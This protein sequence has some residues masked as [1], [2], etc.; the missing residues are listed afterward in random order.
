MNKIHHK[1]K[2]RLLVIYIFLGLIIVRMDHVKMTSVYALVGRICHNPSMLSHTIYFKMHFNII[3]TSTPSLFLRGCKTTFL[4]EFPV[5]PTRAVTLRPPL[6]FCTAEAFH[7]LMGLSDV[8]ILSVQA[9]RNFMKHIRSLTKTFCTVLTVLS[10][11]KFTV[12]SPR[13]ILRSERVYVYPN[14]LLRKRN[15]TDINNR[16]QLFFH[17]TIQRHKI[18]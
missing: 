6:R 2:V 13:H 3:V 14:I 9:L 10:S 11:M 18:Q 8:V 4:Y 7:L 5:S 1:T 12:L 15:F 17:S 16:Y